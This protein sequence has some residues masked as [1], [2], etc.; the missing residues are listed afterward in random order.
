MEPQPISTSVGNST[1]SM[2]SFKNPFRDSVTV[3]IS[4]ETDDNSIFTLLK[5]NKF[6]IGPMGI[7]QIPYSFSPQTM[8]ETK[9]TIIVTMSKTLV[10]KYPIRGISESA[11]TSIDFHF[12]TKSRKPLKESIKIRLPGFEDLSP[13]M[14]LHIF[15]LLFLLRFKLIQI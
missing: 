1:S 3:M 14:H 6:N 7:L 2:L 12:K 8:T 15:L 4:L 9:A 13:G 10:W 11:S 5:R